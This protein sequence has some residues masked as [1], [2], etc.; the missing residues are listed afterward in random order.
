M[1]VEMKTE[2]NSKELPQKII[3]TCIFYIDSEKYIENNDIMDAESDNR[4]K[5]LNS[6]LNDEKNVKTV[7]F[8]NCY[9]NDTLNHMMVFMGKNF[10]RPV[11]SIPVNLLYK[12]RIR[13]EVMPWNP[14][15]IK[16]QIDNINNLEDFNNLPEVKKYSLLFKNNFSTNTKN[17]GYFYIINPHFIKKNG[18][19]D[20]H[21]YIEI[22]GAPFININKFASFDIM[23]NYVNVNIQLCLEIV[24]KLHLFPVTTFQTPLLAILNYYSMCRY[25]KDVYLHANDPFKNASIIIEPTINSY[26]VLLKLET[27]L[28]STTKNYTDEQL[29]TKEKH[30]DIFTQHILE[31]VKV[32]YE[33]IW[34]IMNSYFDSIFMHL[35][36]NNYNLMSP[37]DLYKNYLKNKS[38]AL[39]LVKNFEAHNMEFTTKTI[40]LYEILLLKMT[41]TEPHYKDNDELEKANANNQVLY[42]PKND[43]KNTKM[44]NI[45]D[46]K[47]SYLNYCSTAWRMLLAPIIHNTVPKTTFT[48]N[49]HT[50]EPDTPNVLPDIVEDRMWV[51][52]RK[53]ADS[54][55]WM[56]SILTTHKDEDSSSKSNNNN[57]D[58]E[59]TEDINSILISNMKIIDTFWKLSEIRNITNESEFITFLFI[60][61]M[62]F[63]YKLENNSFNTQKTQ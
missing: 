1:D 53:I 30:M 58:K 25:I 63:D 40:I 11:N 56:N 39:Q 3:S 47:G 57:T 19:I 9:N 51:L 8:I 5:N 32:N 45:S 28:M 7:E 24:S 62:Y 23:S 36:I 42:W 41:E 18:V 17:K 4:Q 34:Y 22:P 14:F 52:N 12:I 6:L 35:Q 55:I 37:E 26:K 54:K 48:K 49:E 50:F 10:G 33:Y 59:N 20:K 2:E 38:L 46:Y 31:M 43:F 27:H 16:I 13:D 15:F 61:L 44:V 21:D 29:K 60:Y